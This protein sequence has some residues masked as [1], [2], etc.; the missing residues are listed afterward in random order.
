MLTRRDLFRTAAGSLGAL[1]AGAAA[2]ALS[3]CEATPDNQVII[4]SCGEGE[5]NEALMGQLRQDLP[6]LD[7]RMQYMS[8]GNLAARLKVEGSS[9]EFDIALMLEGGYLMAAED[10]LA[11]L[12]GHF[13]L[14][15]FEDDL[16]ISPK[17]MPFTRECGTF[18]YN[19]EVL[20]RAGAE[21]P[22]SL[23]DL[24]DARFAGMVSM[25]NPKASSTGYNFYY[26][27]VRRLGEDGALAYFDELDKNVYQYTSSGG[28]PATALTQGEAGL[29]LSLMFQLV[30]ERNDGAPTE[31][32]LFPEGVPWTMNGI[33]VVAGHETR[34]AVWEVMRWFYEKGILLDKQRF[35]PDR[36]FKGQDTHRE[37]YP[38]NLTY[39]DMDGLF[40]LDLKERLLSAWN[41]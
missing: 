38:E 7:V 41:H 13:D 5:R 37:G 2:G 17:I 27:V 28:T 3:G 33:S 34:E 10:S 32:C 22:E 12:S 9:A 26:S 39:A 21:P 1:A 8:T 18:A 14:D 19:T 15:V 31:L 24:L 35:V 25:P 36:V 6:D 16:V 20:A 4:Y 30:S 29:G 23:D 11:D 40:D